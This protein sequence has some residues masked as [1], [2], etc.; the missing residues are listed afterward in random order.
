M[1]TMQAGEARNKLMAIKKDIVE[2][3]TAGQ[4]ED[5]QFYDN[6][7][8]AVEHLREIYLLAATGEFT[9]KVQLGREI[10]FT[11]KELADKFGISEADVRRIG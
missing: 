10:G 1:T 6:V 3:K 2:L 4:K 7:L 11:N 9:K 8:N 5:A